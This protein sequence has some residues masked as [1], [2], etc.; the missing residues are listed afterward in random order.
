M[1]ESGFYFLPGSEDCGTTLTQLH[2]GAS[3]RLKSEKRAAWSRG[4]DA[5][6]LR[7]AAASSKLGNFTF[8]QDFDFFEKRLQYFLMS[9]KPAHFRIEAREILADLSLGFV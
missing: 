6:K 8:S 7:H 3:F 1:R 4:E 5:P 9:L 2:P